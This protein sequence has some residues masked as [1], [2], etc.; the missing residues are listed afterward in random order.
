MKKEKDLIE[1]FQ[2][3]VSIPAVI[4]KVSPAEIK[5]E[6]QKNKEKKDDELFHRI[7][8]KIMKLDK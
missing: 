1:D 7:M 6:L 5:N 2:E 3:E 8:K 4:E